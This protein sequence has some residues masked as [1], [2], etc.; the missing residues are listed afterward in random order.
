MKEASHVECQRERRRATR[1]T[2]AIKSKKMV[3]PSS[4]SYLSNLLQLFEDIRVNV[5][6][7]AIRFEHCAG[8]W[9]RARAGDGVLLGQLLT[10]FGFKQLLLLFLNP[11]E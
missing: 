7:D 5:A 3:N 1:G 4:A 10:K 2:L 6:L 8:P 11:P 9:I